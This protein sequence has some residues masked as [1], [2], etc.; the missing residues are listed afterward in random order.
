[1]IITPIHLNAL[2]RGDRGGRSYGAGEASC[3]PVPIVSFPESP[4]TADVGRASQ[5]AKNLHP[6]GEAKIEGVLLESDALFVKSVG[7]SA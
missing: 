6:F 1:M 5:Y 7:E 3:G 2:N 4:L